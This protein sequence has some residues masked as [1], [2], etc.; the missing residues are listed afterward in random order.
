MSRLSTDS[1]LALYLTPTCISLFNGLLSSYR[2]IAHSLPLTRVLLF[3]R[4]QSRFSFTSNLA[5]G[6]VCSLPL[7]DAH[8]IFQLL[9][10]YLQVRLPALCLSDTPL[11][12][13]LTQY[14]LPL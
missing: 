5:T 10:I 13:S 2:G 9:A 7:T 11:S 4:Y 6:V 8:L 14:S 12:A 1:Y 3:H